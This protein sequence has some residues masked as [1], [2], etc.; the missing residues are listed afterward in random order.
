MIFL[1]VVYLLSNVILLQGTF[2]L[3]RAT[4]S[5]F[6]LG[7]WDFVPLSCISNLVLFKLMKVPFIL[8]KIKK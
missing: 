5:S 1:M 8:K 3:A 4:G 2:V 7:V 6:V